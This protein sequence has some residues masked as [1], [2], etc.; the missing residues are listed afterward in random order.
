[1][2][3][4][5]RRYTIATSIRVAFLGVAIALSS[6]DV[7]TQPAPY[8]IAD[9]GTLGGTSAAGYGIEEL[10]QAMVGQ[11]QTSTG[12]YHAFVRG[13][14]G[15]RDLGALGGSRSMAFAIGGGFVVGQ[16]QTAS[17][18]EHAFSTEY[19]R[20][21]P[22]VDLG[23]LGGTWSAA[24]G[25]EYGTIVGASKTTGDAGLRAFVHT[26]GAM[27]ALALDWGGDSVA[28]AVAGSLIVGQACTAGNAACSAFSF[29]DGVVT[30]LGSL[31]G[32][33]VANAV[34]YSEHIAGTS[35]LADQKTTHAFRYANST[36][37]D[38]GT[39]GGA[40]SEGLDVN[41]RGDVVG[42]SDTAGGGRHAFL[43][44]NGVLTDLNTLL[45]AGSGWLLQSASAISDGGQIVGTGTL[46]GVTR[47][48]LLTP[49]FP[50]SLYPFGV[51]S[52]QDSNLPRGAEVGR[53]I[54]FVFSAVVAVEEGVTLYG[55]R[56]TDTLTGPA[57]Y[58]S[59]MSDDATCQVTP[60]VVTCDIASIDSAGL[61]A[62]IY[63]QIRTTGPGS[64]SHT[65]AAFSD[66]EHSS[67]P[68]A[69]VSEE[70][71]AVALSALTLTPSTLAGGKASSA[72]VTLTDIAPYSNDATVRLAS[73]RP[74]IAPVPSTIVVPYFSG[75]P[76][77][78]FNII[79]KVVA[80]PTPVEI[81]ATYG[82]VTV[83]KTLT[84]VPP[85]LSLLS[86]TPTTIIG[87]CGTSAGKITLSGSAPA[88]GAVVTLSNTNAKATAPASVTVPAGA[89]TAT[90][91][92][93]TATVTT[94]SS[95]SA[96]ASY[97]G[98][99][100][101]LAVTVRP[102]RVKTLALS[103]NPATGGTTVNASV[104][105]ECAAPAGGT[106]V[107]LSSSNAAIATPTATSVTIPAGATTGSFSVGTTHPAAATSVSIYATV[108]GVR[109]SA[110]LT[111]NR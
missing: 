28:R 90:F 98:V 32:N 45:P 105:L 74:D 104:T 40:S 29:R 10:G 100:K 88:G 65:A 72:K 48:Y 5:R 71:R 37:T 63:T 27:S 20:A 52:N 51:R 69:T 103:P 101:T 6:T 47:G 76:S 66:P 87:G 13:R 61:G 17:G 86:L 9:L 14:A 2:V 23:T 79:P 53:K 99:S 106:V 4:D 108:Y 81:S 3:S 64:I 30:K 49:P 94:P 59:A 31:G 58:V 82:Q 25:V 8:R 89:S 95:G 111:V 35:T 102:I 60:K 33:S 55:T 44:R 36:L 92:V 77:R 21:G 110:A 85:Q 24:Y 80:E 1:M 50:V 67:Q 43:W 19:Y 42:T 107:S 97:G 12:T 96:T 93:T 38:L 11:A 16:A 84:V 34:S 39:L 15:L 70:N 22:L 57:E 26:N 83:T 73:S 54:S 7:P 91:T 62:E 56:V 109:K 68:D 18:Q 75:S 46:N 41:G 78:T